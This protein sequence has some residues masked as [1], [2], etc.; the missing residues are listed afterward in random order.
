MSR[1]PKRKGRNSHKR[2]PTAMARFT[3]N[4][5]NSKHAIKRSPNGKLSRLSHL[6]QRNQLFH[7]FSI[8][9]QPFVALILK[10]YA[11]CQ[12]TDQTRFEL[13][14]S[15]ETPRKIPSTIYTDGSIARPLNEHIIKHRLHYGVD[16]K[17]DRLPLSYHQQQKVCSTD[18]HAES[19]GKP[20]RQGTRHSYVFKRAT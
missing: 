3:S 10:M 16:I 12:E 5:K 2:V 13:V 1:S 14:P 9:C 6:K 11:H 18:N 20:S 7:V 15:A 19:Q 8:T 17:S 4:W